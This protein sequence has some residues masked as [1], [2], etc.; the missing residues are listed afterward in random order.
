MRKE[1]SKR[2]QDRCHSM[3]YNL[4]LEVAYIHLPYSVGHTDKVVQYGKVLQKCANTSKLELPWS[5]MEAG[6]HNH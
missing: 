1:A 4:I 2:E 6:Y 5:I 3:V